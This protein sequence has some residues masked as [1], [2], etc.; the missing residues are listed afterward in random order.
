MTT[1]NE[2]VTTNKMAINVLESTEEVW[3]A[4]P[5]ELTANLT[6]LIGIVRDSLVVS[7]ILCTKMYQNIYFQIV[8]SLSWKHCTYTSDVLEHKWRASLKTILI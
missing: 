4:V 6:A 2:I 5:E 1:T 8:C 7:E 3:Y